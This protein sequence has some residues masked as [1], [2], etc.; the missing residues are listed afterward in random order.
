[1]VDGAPEE[2]KWFGCEV[3][4]SDAAIDDERRA[5]GFRQPLFGPWW[6]RVPQTT[7]GEL[8][9]AL[10]L[11]EPLDACARPTVAHERKRSAVRRLDD[12]RPGW[13]GGDAVARTQH[14]LVVRFG[15]EHKHQGG[16]GCGLREEREAARVGLVEEVEM[17]DEKT[18]LVGVDVA[19]N[20]MVL[21]PELCT[22]AR[23]PIGWVGCGA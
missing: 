22:G 15:A 5:E 13:V 8:V 3:P 7:A 20:A 16:C 11:D 23:P 21:L 14:V 12:G 17:R 18:C 19:E 1:M 6:E 9:E 4:E 2:G 10:I